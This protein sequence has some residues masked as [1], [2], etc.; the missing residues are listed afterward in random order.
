VGGIV[1]ELDVAAA[2]GN[3]APWV[4]SLVE[5]SAETWLA[6]VSVEDQE[7]AETGSVILVLDAATGAVKAPPGAAD[8]PDPVVCASRLL[9]GEAIC[10]A[11]G[12]IRLVDPDTG[13]VGPEALGG[14]LGVEAEAV[15]VTG[16]EQL[17]VA[18]VA[19]DNGAPVVAS[20]RA[21]GQVVWSSQI[22]LPDCFVAAGGQSGHVIELGGALQVAVG[23]AQALLAPDS[24]R[25][26][27]AVC[28]QMVVTGDGALA[29]MGD[30]ARAGGTG[31][32]RDAADQAR[33]ICQF[34]SAQD[35]MAVDTPAGGRFAVIDDAERLSLVDPQGCQ[36]VWLK[37]GKLGQALFQ[38]HDQEALYYAKVGGLTAVA[39]DTGAERWLAPVTGGASF[40]SA[41][42][43]DGVIVLMTSVDLRGIGPVDGQVVWSVEDFSDGGWYWEAAPNGASRTLALLGPARSKITRLDLSTPFVS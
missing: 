32:Y 43:Q 34:G 42:V 39:L 18:G 38:G 15:A 28:G 25:V 6:A 10:L 30:D 31:S 14:G 19:V 26:L 5:A 9:A 1:W 35:L 2:L 40:R 33:P 41:Y 20:L 23:Q 8:L 37:D 29:T 27:A 13:R 17:V 16:D 36:P 12:E 24:G 4:T 7:T 22:D 3:P 21:E 11:D